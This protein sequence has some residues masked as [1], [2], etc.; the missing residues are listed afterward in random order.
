MKNIV[1]EVGKGCFVVSFFNGDEYVDCGQFHQSGD[2]G[3]YAAKLVGTTP[4]ENVRIVFNME[5]AGEKK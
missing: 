3:A 2:A 1:T 5:L 4:L